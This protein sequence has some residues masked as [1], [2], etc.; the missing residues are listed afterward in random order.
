MDWLQHDP[1][2]WECAEGYRRFRDFVKKLTIVND[3]A[4]R[5][6]GLVK[7]FINTFQN[8]A[9]C[10]DNLLAVS[11]HRKTVQKNSNKSILAKVG[12]N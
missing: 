7:Q 12:L 5:C 11:K 3:P 9:S 10:Q 4:E 8:E 1:G 2:Q 6:V